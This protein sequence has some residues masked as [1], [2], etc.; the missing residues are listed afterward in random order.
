MNPTS[1]VHILDDDRSIRKSLSWMLENAGLHS[2]AHASPAEFLKDIS[3]SGP[4][5]LILDMHMPGM[6]GLEVLQELAVRPGLQMPT[7]VLTGA[8]TINIAVESL[9]AGAFDFLEKPVDPTTLL[10]K[11]R[12]ALARDTTERA[13]EDTRAALQKKIDQLT[14]RE[15]EVLALLCEGKSSKQIGEQLNISMKTVSIHRW[16]LMKKMQVGSATEAVKIAFQ[17]RAA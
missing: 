11:V 4:S 14:D 12:D 16:H 5:C 10:A 7:I 13:L 3:V 17:A 9:K 1:T 8:G 2:T 6:S 15:Q